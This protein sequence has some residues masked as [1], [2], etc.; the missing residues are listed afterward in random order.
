MIGLAHVISGPLALPVQSRLTYC[1]SSFSCGWPQSLWLLRLQT[2]V[3]DA[4]RWAFTVPQNLEP[5]KEG[6]VMICVMIRRLI[7][8]LS[9]PP[10]CFPKDRVSTKL[11]GKGLSCF[12]LFAGPIKVATFNIVLL[13][14]CCTRPK[15]PGPPSSLFKCNKIAKRS[16]LFKF[17]WRVQAPVFYARANTGRRV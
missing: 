11:C 8:I 2:T 15:L 14:K 13:S 7:L 9:P 4:Q 12:K 5:V 1:Q 10:S 6:L 3:R 17:R 16:S